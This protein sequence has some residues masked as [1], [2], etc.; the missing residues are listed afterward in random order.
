MKA[1]RVQKT[2]GPVATRPERILGP[3]RVPRPSRHVASLNPYDAVSSLEKV[4]QCDPDLP[5][6]KLDWNESTV[7]TSSRVLEAIGRSLADSHPLNWYP[8]LRAGA[9]RKALAEYTGVPA[10]CILVTNGSDAALDLICRTYLEA[11]DEVLV[12]SPTYGH[13]LVFARA[14]GARL[15]EVHAS[16]PFAVP[17]DALLDNLSARTQLLYLAS[18]NNPT[19]VITPS[20]DVARLCRSSSTTLVVVDEAYFEFCGE[21]C[22]P[23]VRVLP[24]LVVTRTFSK[25]FSIAGLRVGY[26]LAGED[27]MNHLLKLHNPKS[28]NVLGQAAALAAIADRP[29]YEAYVA[30][31]R[32][33][34]EFLVEALRERGAIARMTRANFVL[35]RVADPGGLVRSLESVAVFVRDRSQMKGLEGYVRITVG[36]RAQ[37]EDLVRRLDRLLATNPGLLTPPTTD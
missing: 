30:E 8:D 1:F 27:V 10:D 4:A 22:A 37:M 18:P 20:E 2:G 34:G 35:V 6:L 11:G 36:T 15:I 7:D 26:L 19:G 33:A 25:C 28:V 12:A 9:L 3:R 32:A 31:V 29:T 16:S 5:P 24:N 23:L 21:T 17:T 14:C 13:F